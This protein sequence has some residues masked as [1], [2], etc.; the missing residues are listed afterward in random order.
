MAICSIASLD[1]NVLGSR[2]VM[3]RIRA[4]IPPVF[5]LNTD[6]ICLMP[7]LLVSKYMRLQGLGFRG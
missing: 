3:S 1:R 6:W 4:Y 5:A 7:V 2:S